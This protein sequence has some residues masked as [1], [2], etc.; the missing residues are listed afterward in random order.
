MNFGP[1]FVALSSTSSTP[2]LAPP[3]PRGH[4]VPR[5]ASERSI[6]TAKVRKVLEGIIG[7]S[8]G[9]P[10]ERRRILGE[11][12]HADLQRRD[13]PGPRRSRSRSDTSTPSTS[14]RR[15]DE[16]QKDKPVSGKPEEEEARRLR[17]RRRRG[18]SRSEAGRSSLNRRG[19]S[20]KARYRRLTTLLVA[21]P[22]TRPITCR[23]TAAMI[24]L[25]SSA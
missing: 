6:G 18:R 20:K 16:G 9:A 2:R 3:S 8:A 5:M 12:A 21:V 13:P 17:R 15:S 25:S 4:Q 19:A 22:S 23:A 7:E 10:D 11:P 24:R 14:C 1:G